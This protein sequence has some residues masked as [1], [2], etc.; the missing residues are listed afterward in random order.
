V[1]TAFKDPHYSFD[2]S[3]ELEI[4]YE[5]A[6]EAKKTKFVVHHSI[7]CGRMNKTLSAWAKDQN[8]IPWVA[9]AAQVPV[10]RQS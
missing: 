7:Q 3:F 10:S 2:H 9:V 5:S 4:E 8:Y 6:G 1:K